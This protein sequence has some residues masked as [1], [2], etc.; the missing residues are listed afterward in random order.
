MAKIFVIVL[1]TAYC[2]FVAVTIFNTIKYLVKR[3]SKKSAK[4]T[5]KPLVEKTASSK[6]TK[7][8]SRPKPSSS[9][10]FS[11]IDEL[12]NHVGF[13]DSVKTFNKPTS[14]TNIVEA[15]KRLH[16]ALWNVARKENVPIFVMEEKDLWSYDKG[17]QARGMCFLDLKHIRILKK[18]KDDPWVLSHELGHYF[19]HKRGLKKHSEADADNE[20]ERICF[21][22]INVV[23]RAL[24][25]P[26]TLAAL[27]RAGLR[28]T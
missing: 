9:D 22:L 15:K 27:R 11:E 17:V 18:Y 21:S 25:A 1:I 10:L 6:T 8:P 14:H 7:S 4:T 19:L 16:R 3:K 20:A 23:D 24:L 26:Y 2:L 5:P 28:N 13:H 12:L